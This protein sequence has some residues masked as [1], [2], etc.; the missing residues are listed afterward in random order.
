MGS[1]TEKP[2][3]RPAVKLAAL[4]ISAI[5]ALVTGISVY[6]FDRDWAA[7]LFLAP[8]ADRHFGQVGLFGALGGNLPSFLHAYAFALLLIILLGR[9]PFARCLGASL[10]F[11][12]AAALECLQAGPVETLLYGSATAPAG[13]SVLGSIQAYIVNGHFDP[14]DLFAAALGCVAAYAVSSVLEEKQ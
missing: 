4:N 7:T 13:T 14:G 11:S 10:W 9:S 5:L 12:I 1:Y 2:F 6:L 3:Q 8:F